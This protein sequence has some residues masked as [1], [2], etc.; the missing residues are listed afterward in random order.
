[1]ELA[2]IGTDDFVTGFQLAGVEKTYAVA[3]STELEEKLELALTNA[4]I[5]IVVLEE[6]Q[7]EKLSNKSKKRLDKIVTPVI[8]M[9]SSKGKETDLRELIKRTVGVDLWK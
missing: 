3:S 5:G 1:M 8:V 9:L 6:E 7:L 2:I 4:D